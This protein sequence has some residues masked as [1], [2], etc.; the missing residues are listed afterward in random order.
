[1]ATGLFRTADGSAQVDYD[2]NNIPIPRSK[3][4]ENEYNPTSISCRWRRIIGRLRRR[5]ESARPRGPKGE[6]H[7][8]SETGPGF[9]RRGRTAS[10]RRALDGAISSVPRVTARTPA[11]LQPHQS[12]TP[13]P[14][15]PTITRSTPPTRCG[16]TVPPLKHG[17]GPMR[18]GRRIAEQ[19]TTSRCTRTI[20]SS[21]VRGA[22]GGGPTEDGS[23][24]PPTSAPAGKCQKGKK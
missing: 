2:G 21:R 20:R 12:S 14:L 17:P 16:R 15:R 24:T 7:P 5:Q 22:S 6:A 3:Y 1:M 11:V 4:E 8:E 18:S 10:T 9:G 13:P 19:E 23:V